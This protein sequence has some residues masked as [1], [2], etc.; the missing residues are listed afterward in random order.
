MA[1]GSGRADR[2]KLAIIEI[3]SLDVGARTR[4]FGR[5]A[6]VVTLHVAEVL[7]MIRLTAR[8]V[9]LRAKVF[10]H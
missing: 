10:F 3:H 1:K 2:V 4:S 5:F 8:A 7:V 6:L 9:E